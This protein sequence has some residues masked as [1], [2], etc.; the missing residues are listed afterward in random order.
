MMIPP[1]GRA[2]ICGVL[3]VGVQDDADKLLRDHGLT[4]TNVVDLRR[5]AQLVYGSE[6][7][8]RMGL[9]KM[10]GM[11][12]F[13]EEW[14]NGKKEVTSSRPYAVSSADAFVG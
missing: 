8:M 13:L 14:R 5:L 10:D 2:R 7:F 12:K 9:K 6:Q 4:V 11:E 3:G 1:R